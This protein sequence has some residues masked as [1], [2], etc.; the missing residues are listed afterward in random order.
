[1][2]PIE[3]VNKGYITWEENFQIIS[4]EG[5]NSTPNHKR[6]YGTIFKRKW[7]VKFFRYCF[8]IVKLNT[9][10]VWLKF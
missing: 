10:I 6:I 1:M 4:W 9:K 3:R 8:L 7:W 5:R 2:K